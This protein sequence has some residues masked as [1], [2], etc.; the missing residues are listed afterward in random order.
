MHIAKWTIDIIC[1]NNIFRSIKWHTASKFFSKSVDV[2]VTL[3]LEPIPNVPLDGK[4]VTDEIAGICASIP[5]QS[6]AIVT[7]TES[8]E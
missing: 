6:S 8:S 5:G 3:I 1:F 4:N 2:I 7:G